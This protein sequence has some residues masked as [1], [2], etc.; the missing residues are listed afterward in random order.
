MSGMF[1]LNG[2]QSKANL[3]GTVRHL[4]LGKLKLSDPFEGKTFEA[5]IDADFTGNSLN[6]MNGVL[7]IS[8]LIVQSGEES[9]K[10]E[11]LHLTAANEGN[12]RYLSMQ[13]DFADIDLIGQYDY[14]SLP[15]SI[16]NF[17]GSKLPTL[18][19]LPKTN[20]INK[21]NFSIKATVIKSDWLNTFF[22][23]P[24]TLMAPLHLEGSVNDHVQK[25][26][27]L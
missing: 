27:L 1:Y 22:N 19:G 24:V 18:P 14:A 20:N 2:E 7:D 4:N 21:N 9:Y 23:I 15:Q 11:K 16:I 3:I 17:I 5:D 13:S 10:L 8:N 25:I 12:E 6:N 26:F